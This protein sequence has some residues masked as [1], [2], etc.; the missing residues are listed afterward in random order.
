MAGRKRGPARV[1]TQLG[2]Y[3]RSIREER[4]LNQDEFQDELQKVWPTYA[5]KPQFISKLETGAV[6]RPEDP[7]FWDALGKLTGMPREKLE[8]MAFV[9]EGSAKTIFRVVAG[10]CIWAAPI[11]LASLEGQLDSF[12]VCTFEWTN[13]NG[14]EKTPRDFAWIKPREPIT[15]ANVPGPNATK[16][17]AS[18]SAPEV[19]ELL[20]SGMDHGDR[21]DVALV[22]GRLVDENIRS[23]LLRVGCVVDSW[24]GCAFV[25][26]ERFLDEHLAPICSESPHGQLEVTSNQLAKALQADIANKYAGATVYLEEGTVADRMLRE[27]FRVGQDAFDAIRNR[28]NK[29]FAAK[30]EF[31]LLEKKV[32]VLLKKKETQRIFA[33][34]LTWEPQATWLKT[35]ATNSESIRI[36][37]V[38][39]PIGAD[40]RP[41][42]LTF[43]VVIRRQDANS[44]EPRAR[45]FRR[46]LFEMMKILRDCASRL[47]QLDSV[48]LH[49][50][51]SAIEKIGDY[52][53]LTDDK[54]T[55]TR[56]K[57]LASTLKAIGSVNYTFHPHIE[58]LRE[59]RFQPG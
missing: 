4:G 55:L 12:E 11:V 9:A 49:S 20:E 18:L 19:L 33:G 45:Q 5:K 54:A 56:S 36:I 40:G 23:G 27:G 59:M 42:N 17:N 32:S 7:S 6:Q 30:Q 28:Q 57:Q 37:P 1:A 25:C 48:T 22:P 21:I 35:T 13:E 46:S 29:D 34:I 52:F 38:K 47:N 15:K 53:G 50:D 39:F 43:E 58:A 14:E 10:H 51:P 41:T 31:D 24:T 2:A 16:T 8:A 26:R 3:I 44:D